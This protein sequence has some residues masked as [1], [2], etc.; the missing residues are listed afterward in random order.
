MKTLETIFPFFLLIFLGS[1]ARRK[2]FIP[3]SFQEPANRLIYYFA[4]P[5]LVFRSTA[6][7][8]LDREFHLG[9]LLATLAASA[10]IYTVT[11]LFCHLKS[12]P[13]RRCSAIV[14]SV[15]H[16]NLGYIG[17]P[18]SLYYLGESGLAK[19]AIIAS[20]MVILQNVLSVSALQVFSGESS[21][22]GNKLANVFFNLCKNPVILSSLAGIVA[23]DVG[24]PMPKMLVHFLEMLGS[25]APPM[26]L[27]LIGASLNFRK[28]GKDL[29]MVVGAVFIKLFCLPALG[30]CLYSIFRFPQESFL[31]GLLLLSC[32]TAAIT[33]V[34]A[35][36]MK[37]DPDFIVST[38]S[39]STLLSA[40]S[41]AVWMGMALWLNIG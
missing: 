25:I 22:S 31:P 34:M 12:F 11:G 6:L 39:V 13:A 17:L 23:S 1:V 33:Y 14:Q 24:L 28:A 9:V 20:V 27:L 18:F 3:D 35:K 5:A 36:E 15:G 32:P 4:I 16:G 26:A 7:A 41:F 2:G 8:S 10:T 40:V 37:G 30:L 19:T 29:K 21:S 38:I